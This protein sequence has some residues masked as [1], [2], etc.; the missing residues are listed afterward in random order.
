MRL[1]QI[2]PS[3]PW[4]PALLL[5]LCVAS[6]GSAGVGSAVSNHTIVDTQAP[7]LQLEPLGEYPLFISGDIV[8]FTWQSDEDH[9]S[10]D[11]DDYTA[12]IWI[13]QTIESEL[14]WYPQI[15]NFIWNWTVPEI[16]TSGCRLE[17]LARDAYGNTALAVSETF[18][19]LLATTD[20]PVPATVLNLN[21]PAP[22]PFNPAT[23]VSFDLP[24]A[25]TVEL[26][27]YD[28]RGHR[29]RTLMAGGLEAGHHTTRWDGLDQAGRPQP[30]GLYLF[31][32]DAQTAGETRRLVRKAVLLP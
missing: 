28:T 21:Q 2:E 16:Q 31:V 11:P 18:S 1:R 8:S 24:A 30:G 26:A 5:V 14:S 13:N 17:V 22:N 4:L 23:N 7:L 25:A 6:P 10:A 32:M 9:P 15:E 27:V 19:I 12:T 3:V 20:V 29:V